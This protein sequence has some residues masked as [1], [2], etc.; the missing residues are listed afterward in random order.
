MLNFRKIQLKDR[1]WINSILKEHDITG[2]HENFGN[3]FAWRDINNTRVARVN[4]FLLV[5]QEIGDIKDIYLYPMGKGNVKPVIDEIIKSRDSEGLMMAGLSLKQV[6]ELSN[7]YPGKFI[8]QES[9]MDFDYIYRIEKLVTL[10]GKKLHR[11]RNHIS[12]FMRSYPDWSFEPLTEENKD[13]CIEMNKKWCIDSDCQQD[14]GLMDENCATKYFFKYFKDLELEGGLIRAGGRVV[15]YTIGE[16]LSSD[17]YVIHIE[18]AFKDVQGAYPMINQQFAAW[19]QNNHPDLIYINREEDMG[20]E[21]L[22][23]AKL[24]YYPDKMAVKFRAKLK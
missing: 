5:K 3:L 11:K 7:L 21:G 23:K 8:F 15:A 16:V 12:I 2:C 20:L 4:E 10:R 6:N 17:T 13:E 14:Q 24:S 1:Q 19:V 9:R 18:K 22:R